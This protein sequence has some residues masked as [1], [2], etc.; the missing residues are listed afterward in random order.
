[1]R[2]KRRSGWA[3]AKGDDEGERAHTLGEGGS[4]VEWSG[5]R[6]KLLAPS[7]CSFSLLLL[8]LFDSLYFFAF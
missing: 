4:G 6:V 5:E 3:A 7:A 8:V 1:M 2:E